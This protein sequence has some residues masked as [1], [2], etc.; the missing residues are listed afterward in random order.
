M[1]GCCVLPL[2]YG[3]SGVCYTLGSCSGGVG[4]SCSTAMLNM[5]A[6][7]FSDT[8]CFYQSYR[9]GMDRAGLWRASVRSAAACVTA[10]AGDRLGNLLCTGNSS[11]VLE[12]H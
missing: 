5:A 3:G 11:I 2:I 9:M 8:L 6:N 12:T 7:C 1:V 4:G 10:S